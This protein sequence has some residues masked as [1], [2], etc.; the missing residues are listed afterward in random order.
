MVTQALNKG[1]NHE[2]MRAM[3]SSFM[4]QAQHAEPQNL[5]HGYTA[6]IQEGKGFQGVA[7]A[8]GGQSG[9]PGTGGGLVAAAVRWSGSGAG[10]GSG[11]AGPAVMAEVPG[12]VVAADQAAEWWRGR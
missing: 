7:G 6:A 10:G 9:G 12:P 1:F 3:R 5:A 11:G 2:D 4:N 8:A